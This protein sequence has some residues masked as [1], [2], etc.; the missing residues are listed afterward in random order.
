MIASLY[1]SGSLFMQ[2]RAASVARGRRW[3]GAENFR[4]PPR[5]WPEGP[6]DAAGAGT[7]RSRD[8]ATTIARALALLGKRRLVL[9]IHD[10]S[11]P[12]AQGED[13][14]RGSPYTRGGREF[15]AWV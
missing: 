13:V 7:R 6:L 4:D 11:L 5:M 1:Q 12:C 10:P 3:R 9:A 8:M 14:G 2:P 15:L